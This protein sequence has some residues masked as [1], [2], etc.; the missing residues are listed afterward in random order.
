LRKRLQ[1][2]PFK[3]MPN[4]LLIPLFQHK[5]W[6]N[7]EQIKALEE[8]AKT[9]SR[10]DLA[11]PL[12]T[13]DHTNRVD[14][15]FKARLIGETPDLEVVA[16]RFPAFSELAETVAATDAWYLDYV[17]R[18]TEEDLAETVAFTFIIDGEPGCMTRAEI[19]AHII[20]HGAS[21]RGA[22]GRMLETLKVAGAPDMVTTFVSARRKGAA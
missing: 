19:L 4:A 6:A 17:S 3:I 14:R 18:V 21:H 12:F 20:T 1:T 7:H 5:A 13:F 22:I 10:A 2:E 16:T 9:L 8:A 11:L 15:A